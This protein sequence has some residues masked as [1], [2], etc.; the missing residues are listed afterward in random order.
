MII[1]NLSGIVAANCSSR[2]RW[3]IIL[4]G[5]ALQGQYVERLLYI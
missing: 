5:W 4:L 3:V 2:T 1:P